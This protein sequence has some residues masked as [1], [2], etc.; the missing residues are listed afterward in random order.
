MGN[1]LKIEDFKRQRSSSG[2]WGCVIFGHY[3]LISYFE[4][5][6]LDDESQSGFTRECKS[7]KAF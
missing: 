5:L 2:V 1:F 6:S 4:R 3:S 7:Q